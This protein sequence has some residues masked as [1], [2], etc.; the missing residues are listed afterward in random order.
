[1]IC[2]LKELETAY[3]WICDLRIKYS[4]HNDIWDLRRDWGR[5]K[6]TL[7]GSYAKRV[8]KALKK[9]PRCPSS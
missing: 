9:H 2:S 1:M 8:G 4:P 3:Q 5:L 7:F 6:E